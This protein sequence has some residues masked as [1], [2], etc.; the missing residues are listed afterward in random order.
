MIRNRFF[1]PEDEIKRDYRDKGDLKPYN[2]TFES[3]YN[4]K[5]TI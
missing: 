2:M 4:D 1:I 3:D 5:D